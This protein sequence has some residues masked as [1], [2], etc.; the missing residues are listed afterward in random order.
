[1]ELPCAISLTAV[2]ET[3][4]GQTAFSTPSILS[5]AGFSCVT[6]RLASSTVVF[7][8]QLPAMKGTRVVFCI[9]FLPGLCPEFGQFEGIGHGQ[10]HQCGGRRAADAA[11]KARGLRELDRLVRTAYFGVKERRHRVPAMALEPGGRRMIAGND[12]DVRLQLEQG[13]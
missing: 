3:N 12:D 2:S 11:R 13:G 9:E 1:M 5:R 8:F 7:I 4:G 6:R 10:R